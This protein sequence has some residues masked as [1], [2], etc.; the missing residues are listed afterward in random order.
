MAL[1]RMGAEIGTQVHKMFRDMNYRAYKQPSRYADQAERAQR[2]RQKAF[3]ISLC[4]KKTGA[5][6]GLTGAT[7]VS[8]SW[9]G[10]GSP[11]RSSFH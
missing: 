2:A 6:S 5:S 8:A 9:S 3:G 11:A 10:S 4:R 7:S 1:R